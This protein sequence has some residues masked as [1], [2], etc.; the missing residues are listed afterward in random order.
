MR[1]PMRA[2]TLFHAFPERPGFDRYD[3]DLVSPEAPCGAAWLVNCLL[4]LGIAAWKP[5]G[6]DDRAHWQNLDRF[7]YRY[8]GG[9]NGW[10]RV[11]PALSAGREFDFRPDHC[12]R[13]HH[14][15]PGLYPAATHRLLFVRDPREA[16]Y[17]AWQRQLRT[18]ADAAPDFTAFCMSRFFHYPISWL[19]YLLLFLRVWRRA[20]ERDGAKILR[21]EDYR[22]DA[23]ATLLDVTG[24]LGITVKPEAAQ[25]AVDA[26]AVERIEAEDRRLLAAG[27]VDAL[28]VRGTRPG[29]DLSRFDEATHRQ[30]GSR[31]NDLCDW[32]RYPTSVTSPGARPLHSQHEVHARILDAF[33]H[34]AIPVDPAGWLSIAVFDAVADIDLLPVGAR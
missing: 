15:W 2:S 13:A 17:S 32:L 11:L 9:D 26:S 18:R 25:R 28:I 8:A 16:L 10:S 27:V 30:V 3:I 5:W 22:R 21:F 4:E 19:D 24:Y 34:A 33:E 6:S 31:F 23:L 29:A 1:S 12:V 14:T 7:R 20:S